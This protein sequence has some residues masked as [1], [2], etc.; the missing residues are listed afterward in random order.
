MMMRR[1]GMMPSLAAKM[2]EFADDLTPEERAQV[3]ASE[4]SGPGATT[5]REKLERWA[6]GL[7]AEEREGLR[8]A[9][10]HAGSGEDAETRGF[11]KPLYDDGFGYKGPP[12]PVEG[13]GGGGDFGGLIPQQYKDAWDLLTSLRAHNIIPTSITWPPY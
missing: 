3:R 1:Y 10:A 6:A 11:M 2:R 7:T 4:G 8:L 13:Q 12:R 5:V 9:L